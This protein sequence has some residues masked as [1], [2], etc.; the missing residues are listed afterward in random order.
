[1]HTTGCS[2]GS[3]SDGFVRLEMEE[4]DSRM[5]D[6][7]LNDDEL[8]YLAE[9]KMRGTA[10]ELARSTMARWYVR[11]RDAFVA[12]W[13]GDRTHITP[14][15]RV[16][17]Q[18][19]GHR[20]FDAPSRGAQVACVTLVLGLTLALAV[21]TAR[22]SSSSAT[23]KQADTNQ[24]IKSSELPGPIEDP[25]SMVVRLPPAPF[26][27]SSIVVNEPSDPHEPVWRLSKDASRLP[28]CGQFI[29]LPFLFA[30]WG[31]NVS[32]LV[33]R[34]HV[35]RQLDNP[36]E[37]LTPKRCS[38]LSLQLRAAMYARK[39][40]IIVLADNNSWSYGRLEY[41][42]EPYTIDCVP[43]SDWYD[44]KQATGIR[45]PGWETAPRL[46]V[47]VNDLQQMDDMDQELFFDSAKDGMQRV[48]RLMLGRDPK[49]SVLPASDTLP[50]SLI[51]AFEDYAELFQT[52]FKP[53]PEILEDVERVKR[54]M[55]IGG[56]RPTIAVQVRLGDKRMEYESS[57]RFIENTF[58]NLTAHLEVMH[59]LYDRLVGCPSV[60]KGTC[61]PLS[62][63]ARRFSSDNA[64]PRA[65]L[66]TLEENALGNM[67]RNSIAAPFEFDRTPGMN[68]FPG[69][70]FNQWSFVN[71]P[72]KARVA[73][74]RTVVRDIFLAAKETDATVV[75]MGSNLGRLVALLAGSESVLGPK[76]STSGEFVGGR[77]RALDT[78]W[79][80]L[81]YPD[82]VWARLDVT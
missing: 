30:G 50:A 79:F 53:V 49:P 17:C 60:Q 12:R 54:L 67:A 29:L 70:S 81:T 65:I 6:E 18:G 4:N 9:P 23:A 63:T 66:L 15:K 33:R 40:G 42:L 46:R 10:Y 78:P 32:L 43:P 57:T 80:S 64:R 1:M 68:V 76:H 2:G 24:L 28:K 69:S 27:E 75:T 16:D 11:V 62:P 77:I 8:E 36:R 19:I 45:Q 59:D 39:L 71:M 58:G 14:P 35:K 20:V 74:A 51:S 25:A 44:T 52:M 55:G 21:Q 61:Y 82:G 7:V 31:A 38:Y 72:L 47:G 5:S 73:S 26:N 48:Q 37:V 56:K 41:Y 13:M 3:G 34:S 22:L